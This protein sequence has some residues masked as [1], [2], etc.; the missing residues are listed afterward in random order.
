M[1]SFS[2]NPTRCLQKRLERTLRNIHCRAG[3]GGKQQPCWRGKKLYQ[4]LF[5]WSFCTEQQPASVRRRAT[6]TVNLKELANSHDMC[7][8]Q[9]GV[10][11]LLMEKRN[12]TDS[13]Y[14]CSLER[15]RIAKKPRPWRWSN[16]T[17][18]WLIVT[19]PS[20][21]L[22]WDILNKK[23]QQTTTGIEQERTKYKKKLSLS[24]ITKWHNIP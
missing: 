9:I 20:P 7:S 18:L 13:T 21:L 15:G 4:I 2:A 14:G 17:C 11:T 6:G 10:K 1:C 22:W 3:P 5:S 23:W 24:H 19:P 12:D 16:H 8:N